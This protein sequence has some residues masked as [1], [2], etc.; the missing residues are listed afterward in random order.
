MEVTKSRGLQ[1][2][3]NNEERAYGLQ[4]FVDFYPMTDGA[5]RT[6]LNA[7]LSLFLHSVS[8]NAAT[9]RVS[10]SLAFDRCIRNVPI[11]ILHISLVRS[12][13]TPQRPARWK[14]LRVFLHRETS[15]QV[16]ACPSI[17]LR[18]LQGGGQ[19]QMT[20]AQQFGPLHAH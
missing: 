11:S 3:I 12:L 17:H 8:I 15:I 5:Q 7:V 4:S 16:P 18:Q 9:S 14:G 13:Q 10:L 6:C 1:V 20:P 19:G 2:R